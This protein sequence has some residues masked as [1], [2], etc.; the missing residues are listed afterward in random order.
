MIIHK[1]LINIL[2]IALS[3]IPQLA[4]AQTQS[5]PTDEEIQE[6]MPDFQ[7]EVEYWNQYEEP[8]RQSEARAFAENWSRRDPAIVLFLGSWSGWEETTD[9]YPS[10]TEGQVCI[11]HTSEPEASFSLGQVF[12]QRIYT[13]RGEV[14][15]QQGNYVGVAWSNDNEAG[16]E[17]GITAYRLIAPT[18][19]LT[20]ESLSY[21]D[22]GDRIIEQFNAAG[23]IA[24]ALAAMVR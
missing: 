4:Y 7:R 9:I 24:E 1:R 8:E 12:N 5:Y 10:K 23:C 18:E 22:G 14:I 21:W 2:A 17:A 20:S 19:V 6:L 16:I 15:F 13:D 3:I 11:I